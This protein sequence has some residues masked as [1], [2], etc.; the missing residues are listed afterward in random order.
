[1]KVTLVYAGITECGFDSLKGNEGSWM[2]HGL[3]VLSS[4]IKRKGH[5]VNLLD[6]R[7]MTGWD[8]VRARVRKLDSKVV[9]ITMMS[10]DYNPAKRVAEII[11]E[12]KPEIKV[13]VGG[14]HPSILAEELIPLDCF[15]YVHTKEGEI[16][17]P[18]LL[19]SIE[20][21]EN[22]PKLVEGI[23]CHNLDE[24]PFADRF[25]FEC[26]E[27]P[28]VPFL[29]PP[30][31]TLIAGR[32]C[33]YNCNY[34]QPAEKLIF[35][36]GV[37]RR[38]VNN[39]IEELKYLRDTFNFS[40]MMLHDDCLTE[41]REWVLE[42]AR[43]YKEEGFTQPFVCQSR[44]DLIARRKEMIEA[45][46]DAGLR[47]LIIGFESGSNR[48][49]NFL[50]K[51]STR[52]INLKA[53]EICHE[54]GIKIWANYMMGL[55]TETKEEAM[56]TY[57]MLELI[58]PYH[59]SPAFYT[60]HPGSDL[61]DIG[62]KLGIHNIV[63]HDSY[64]RNSYDEKIKGVDYVFLKEMLWKSVAL[65]EDMQNPTPPA[66]AATAR[67]EATQQYIVTAPIKTRAFNKLKGT[68]MKVSPRLYMKL[69]DVYRSTKGVSTPGASTGINGHFSNSEGKTSSMSTHSQNLENI[70]KERQA[71]I[72]NLEEALANMTRHAANL[73]GVVA[74]LNKHVA[75]LE[76]VI[77][78]QKKTL[79]DKQTSA[80]A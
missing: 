8:D 3:C 56:E 59:C 75:N 6:L 63:T 66:A 17:F 16:S 19:E 77:Q 35:G 12:E 42:F 78:K 11:K 31:V 20:K 14:P 46:Y 71:H 30:F 51:G 65:A 61:Y 29:K 9:G 54:M 7:R 32:G 48:M 70:A 24:V 80:R 23:G 22:R 1:M 76:G 26:P 79:E 13:V 58:K 45:L 49:L 2:N 15:D 37:R 38:S 44:A 50:R 69:R 27:E 43:R 53:A 5:E 57:T 40:S 60:P 39:M 34:C 72:A 68:L 21:G 10:V 62:E 73:E 52:E 18:A 36:K 55:P 41:D 33:R 67:G 28:F 25:L 74:N 4:A 64:R 47:L